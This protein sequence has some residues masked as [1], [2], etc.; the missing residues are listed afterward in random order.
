MQEKPEIVS[1]TRP[2]HRF[3]AAEA[4]DRGFE[5]GEVRRAIYGTGWEGSVVVTARTDGRYEV[6]TAG[7]SPRVR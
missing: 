6:R 2:P 7:P 4:A 5:P 1:M 3:W